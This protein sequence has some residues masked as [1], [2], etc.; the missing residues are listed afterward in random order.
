FPG[1]LCWLLSWTFC[2]PPAVRPCPMPPLVHNGNHNG[3][4][5]AFFT[6][7]MSVTYTCDPGYY[8]VGNANVF[9]RASG[10]WSRGPRCEEVT[11]PWPPNIANGLHS[12]K[13]GDR[14]SQGVAV[15]YSCKDGYTLVGNVSISCTATGVWSR[16]LP[17][18]EGG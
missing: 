1:S 17:R 15:S 4:G 7:G 6:M 10:N 18:C 14:F 2:L 12:G 13:P 8:L 11:C 9:C 16:S 3:Q 5:K